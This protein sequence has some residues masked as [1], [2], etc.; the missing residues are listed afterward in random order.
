MGD[1]ATARRWLEGGRD[2]FVNNT[3]HSDTN[4]QSTGCGVLFIN[5]LRHQRDFTIEQIIGAPGAT[6]RETY[7]KLTK[8]TEDPFPPFKELLGRFFPPGQP[9]GLVGDNPFPLGRWDSLG[10]SFAHA[11][12]MVAAGLEP[13]QNRRHCRGRRSPVRTSAGE[14]GAFGLVVKPAGPLV[15]TPRR[16]R[17]CRNTPGM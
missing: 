17:R 15:R 7:S 6:L 13:S 10:G 4:P 12:A 5:Y 11:P 3:D 1:F 16:R 9:T 14:E 2:D 8:S